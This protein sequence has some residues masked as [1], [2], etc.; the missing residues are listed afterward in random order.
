M[1]KIIRENTFLKTFFFWSNFILFSCNHTHT[2]ESWTG[3][4]D[5]TAAPLHWDII[6]CL[7][8]SKF[9]YVRASLFIAILKAVFF[10]EAIT[11]FIKARESKRFCLLSPLSV[12]FV[13]FCFSFCPGKRRASNTKLSQN[14][15][16]LC[17]TV[18]GFAFNFPI[19]QRPSHTNKCLWMTVGK[20]TICRIWLWFLFCFLFFTFQADPPFPLCFS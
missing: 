9:V 4:R 7:C 14:V 6:V 13:I 5:G 20:W 2:L 18:F 10:E 8:T 16:H 3:P 17:N 1:F 12:F 19:T 11:Y 15:S